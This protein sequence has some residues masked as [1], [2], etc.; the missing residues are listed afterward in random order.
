MTYGQD[1]LFR[2]KGIDKGAGCF[3]GLAGCGI[4][5]LQVGFMMLLVAGA[6]WAGATVLQAMGVV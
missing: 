6:V 4:V 1:P 5:I 2:D 3:V